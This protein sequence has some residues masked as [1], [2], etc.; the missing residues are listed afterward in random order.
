M[1]SGDRQAASKGLEPLGC[2]AD[3]KNCHV[4]HFYFFKVRIRV[5]V[6]IV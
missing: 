2:V 4:F 1:R 6:E 3:P 5:E